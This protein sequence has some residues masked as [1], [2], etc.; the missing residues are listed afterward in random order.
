[1]SPKSLLLAS[2]SPYRHA[3]LARLGLPFRAIAPGISEKSLPGETPEARARRLAAAKARAPGGKTAYVIG[4]DQVAVLG[5]QGLDKPGTLERGVRQL[6]SMSGREVCFLTALCL[7]HQADDSLQLDCVPT[8]VRFRP[9]TER[10]VRAYL[11][12]EPAMDCAGSFKSEGLGISLVERI[13]SSDPTALVGLPLIRLG[14]ML[15]TAGLEPP[16]GEPP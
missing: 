16:A 8:W 4:S 6:L 13:C 2:T 15:R 12:A 7:Y 9:L 10:M 3:L 14:E 5:N 11:A 1:M